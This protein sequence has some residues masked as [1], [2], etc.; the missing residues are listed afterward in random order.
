[1]HSHFNDPVVFSLEPKETT[2]QPIKQP[3][4]SVMSYMHQKSIE[5]GVHGLLHPHLLLSLECLQSNEEKFTTGVYSG[6]KPKLMRLEQCVLAP[7]HIMKFAFDLN[8]SS[9]GLSAATDYT[10]QY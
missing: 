4:L 6:H 7:I 8:G 1:M 9:A 10:C 5:L 2:Q 3:F